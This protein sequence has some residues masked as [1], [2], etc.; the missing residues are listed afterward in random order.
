MRFYNNLPKR[1]RTGRKSPYYIPMTFNLCENEEKDYDEERLK[2]I[3]TVKLRKTDLDIS[4]IDTMRDFD[5][6]REI[7][8]KANENALNI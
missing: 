4:S 1:R 2:E 5:Y 6:V 8:K 7:T 3:E